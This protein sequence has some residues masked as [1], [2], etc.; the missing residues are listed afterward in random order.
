MGVVPVNVTVNGVQGQT[1]WS[2]TNCGGGPV[3]I[4]GAMTSWWTNDTTIATASNA[5]VYGVAVGSTDNLAEG[6][7]SISGFRRCSEQ[8]GKGSGGTNVVRLSCTSSVT[9]GGSATCTVTGPSGTTVSGWQFKDSAGNTVARAT[10]TTSLSWSGAMV[11]GGTVSVT[12][13]GDAPLSAS[14]TVNNRTNFAFTAVSP[15]PESDPFTGDGCSVSVPSPPQQ[16][17]DA[18]GIFCLAQYFSVNAATV[19]DNGPNNGYSYVS[20]ISSSSGSSTT[21][22]FYVISPDLENTSST[23]YLAQCG[24]YNPTAQ[25]GFI[26]GANLLADTKRHEAGTVQSHYEN[27]TVAQDNSANNLGTVAESKTGI[28]SAQALANSVT[29]VLNQNVQ[30]IL[31]ATQVQPCSVQQDASCNFQGCINF[32]PYYSCSEVVSCVP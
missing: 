6:E 24:N 8:L 28:E 22:Y 32:S 19:S 17:G 25:T 23:F 12:A 7:I 2:A 29:S 5:N 21:G 31:T 16:S 1:A 3:N 14:I 9:R 10:D 18:V 30:T 26:S 20:S 4:T 11:T 27:Y 15:A 13:N